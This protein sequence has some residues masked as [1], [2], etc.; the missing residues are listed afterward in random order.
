M[1]KNPKTA[2][3]LVRA[4]LLKIAKRTI[5]NVAERVAAVRRIGRGLNT[6][7]LVPCFL[8]AII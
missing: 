7:L 8:M 4:K 3:V 6:A 1:K 2:A 5:A